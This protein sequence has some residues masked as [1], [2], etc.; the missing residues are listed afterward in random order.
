MERDDKGAEW[1]V[2]ASVQETADFP[3]LAEQD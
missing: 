1:E 3:F 2:D